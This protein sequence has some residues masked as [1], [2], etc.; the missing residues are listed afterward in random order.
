MTRYTVVWPQ[1]VQD[2]LAEIW[3]HSQDREA[4]AKAAVEIDRC[5]ACDASIQGAELGEDLRFFLA[6]PL[7]ILYAVR[8]DDRIGE[9][10][11][12]RL[13]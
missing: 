10:L 13:L 4:V 5:L 11:R 3:L 6:P 2:E 7:R 12:V 9:V 8:E 1:E